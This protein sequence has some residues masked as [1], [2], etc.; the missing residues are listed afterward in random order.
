MAIDN[1]TIDNLTDTK[2]I[3]TLRQQ[4][5]NKKNKRKSS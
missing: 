3:L 2:P 4:Q 5:K 1:L